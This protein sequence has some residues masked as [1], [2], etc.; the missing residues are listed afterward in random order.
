MGDPE[1]RSQYDK[2]GYTSAKEHQQQNRGGP[3]GHP[4]HGDPFEGFFHNF[5]FNFGGSGFK[6][7]FVEKND[8]NMR[9]DFRIII[10]F[11]IFD[12]GN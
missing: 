5:K 4:F 6:D 9:Q 8:I 3:F 2:F 11:C 7:S 10:F 1:R 12:T